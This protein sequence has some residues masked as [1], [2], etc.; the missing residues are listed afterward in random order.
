[1]AILTIA[2]LGRASD[3][4]IDDT[5]QEITLLDDLYHFLKWTEDE[6]QQ[7]EVAFKLGGDIRNLGV[8]PSSVSKVGACPLKIFWECTG[9]VKKM[10]PFDT[11]RQDIFDIGTAM[12]E[13]LQARF[14]A[15]YQE[16]F[17]P[18]V[19]LGIPELHITGHCDGVFYFPRYRFILEI[20]TIKESDTQYG[21]AKAQRAPLVE[22]VRQLT[23][24]QKAL[25]IPFGLLFYY[26][27]NNSLKAEHV[28][29]FD[30][31]IWEDLKQFITPIAAAAY[32]GG[33]PVAAK[34]GFNCRFCGF[35][36]SC[37][38]GRRRNDSRSDRRSR[39]G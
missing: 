27:K 14:Q 39:K 4:E 16:Q 35:L 32:D 13:V 11:D 34:A 12:H 33:A 9:D 3:Q 8:H 6:H 20:K 2:D 18:E 38:A 7:Y 29:V 24:Y 22:H 37:K 1:M 31:M 19:K 28:Q 30:P 36:H 23:I 17:V 25:D 26:C 5:V 15:M 21:F 10:E